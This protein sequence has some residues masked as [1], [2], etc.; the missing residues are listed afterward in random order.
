[1]YDILDRIHYLIR[2]CE[3]NGYCLDIRYICN[4]VMESEPVLRIEVKKGKYFGTDYIPYNL[5]LAEP[6]PYRFVE[7]LIV[8]CMNKAK[9]QEQLDIK[10]HRQY[11]TDHF[12]GK[13]QND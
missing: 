9:E 12:R 4:R 7:N 3:E 2:Q 11:I 10:W 8:E 13:D 5:V 1:M 6:D